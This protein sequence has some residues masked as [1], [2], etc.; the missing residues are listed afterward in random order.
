MFQK[1]PFIN[2]VRANINKN[3]NN[4]NV[5]DSSNITNSFLENENV[6]QVYQSIV[7]S[8]SPSLSSPS[9]LN[10]N[11]KKIIKSAI[12][13][14]HKSIIDNKK[15]QQ[16]QK[17]KEIFK[18]CQNGKLE[19]MKQM[20]QVYGDNK[21]EKVELRDEFGWTLLMIAACSGHLAI[22]RLL[23][24]AGANVDA[25]STTG[26]TVVELA[27][28][29]GHDYVVKAIDD[30][31]KQKGKSE[32]DKNDE[33]AEF[34]LQFQSNKIEQTKH[35]IE[36]T[37]CGVLVLESDLI[38]HK[39]SI[40]HQLKVGQF[41]SEETRQLGSYAHVNRNF[42]GYQLL[43][44]QGWNEHSG[45][46]INEDGRKY[47]I[48]ARPKPDRACI[49]LPHMTENKCETRMVRSLSLN[50]QLLLQSQQS[51]VERKNKLKHKLYNEHKRQRRIEHEFRECFRDY[52]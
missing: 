36:C 48:V 41:S 23:L 25:K 43:V 39:S 3:N 17:S 32:K 50:Q 42:K 24:E 29:T 45:L 27:T 26:E 20:L 49:G 2:F 16:T 15:Y 12:I 9:S 31:C 37:D 38:T 30:Y 18:F 4:D 52:T 28:K 47:P 13:E 10:Q 19:Q 35:Q 44:K 6:S 8:S 40:T 7:L 33:V 22:V 21:S 5:Y 11:H 34:Q 1:Q 51:R 46:G 14:D